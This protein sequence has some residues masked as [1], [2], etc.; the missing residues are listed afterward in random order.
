MAMKIVT[1]GE[2]FL[3]I[4]AE[5]GMTWEQLWKDPANK[6]LADK[7][8]LPTILKP[9]DAVYV[10]EKEGTA[11]DRPTDA[12]HRFRL[13][14]TLAK[15]RI[16]VL[17]NGAPLVGTKCKLSTDGADAQETTKPT[18]ANGVFEASI[19][20]TLQQAHFLV[21]E[22]GEEY[23]LKIGWLDPIDSV[24]GLQ[25]RLNNLGFSCGKVDDGWGKK[26]RGGMQSFQRKKSLT[27]TKKP[28]KTTRDRL[29]KE[30]GY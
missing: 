16:R 23:L 27:K 17:S 30:Y 14:G 21:E 3:S 10:P 11:A 6:A 28:D 20:P 22:T 1:Q 29:E 12:K 25:A 24:S 26:T 19:P 5:S 15:L 18:D 13:K 2:C 8:K 7:R 4:A 9:G